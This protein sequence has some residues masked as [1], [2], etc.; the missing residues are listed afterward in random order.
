MRLFKKTNIDF[1]GKRK[2]W[3][4]FSGTMM[5]IGIF[6]VFI[7]GLDFGIDFRGGTEI[8][9]SFQQK[10]EISEVRIAL[11]KIGLGNS[12]IKSYG[13][14]NGVLIRTSEQGEGTKISDNIKNTIKSS[15]PDKKF[16]V[17]KE[18]KIGPKIG[19]E[20]RRDALYAL[21]W[22]FIAILIYVAFRFKFAYGMGAV[23]ALVHDVT[24]TLGFLAILNY[25]APNLNIDISL[26][27]IAALL[28]I[29][30]VSVN[31]TVVIF[32]RIREN[33]KIYRT[34]SLYDVINRSINDTLS[35]TIIT[36]GTIF[37][38]LIVLLI[39]GGDVLRGFA[40]TMF[41]GSIS[42]TYSTIYVA[43]SFVHDWTRYRNRKTAVLNPVQ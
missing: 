18:V 41:F 31:D 22:S 32:D 20:L 7:K 6:A 1:L 13:G 42:G 33:E 25:L 12:E 35:R 9:I 26:E 16:E 34:M 14:E 27:V 15:F 5:L 38:V 40:V 30:G 11:T 2:W 24:A 39:F 19:K 23:I 17:A 21:I 3:Y 4:I 8:V 36:N 37:A 43:S 29:I 28:T 10:V